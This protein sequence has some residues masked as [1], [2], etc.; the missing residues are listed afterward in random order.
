[1]VQIPPSPT[2]CAGEGPGARRYKPEAPGDLRPSAQG[3]AAGEQ[4]KNPG[5]W[6]LGSQTPGLI[7]IFWPRPSKRLRLAP[8]SARNGPSSTPA[9]TQDL[10]LR[11]CPSKI[12]P[13]LY[14][15]N[16]IQNHHLLRPHQHINPS[17]PPP[18]RTFL[19]PPPL[20]APGWHHIL[21]YSLSFLSSP[22]PPLGPP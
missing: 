15:P 6:L 19:T 1:M 9:S 11:P 7:Y 16:Y 17:S 22:P 5:F 18:P 13:P 14:D 4:S 8:P 12:I 10:Q 20:L 3:P 2:W 21:F